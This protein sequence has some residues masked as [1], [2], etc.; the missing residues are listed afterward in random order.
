MMGSGEHYYYTKMCG[1]CDMQLKPRGMD[2]MVDCMSF[3]VSYMTSMMG[4]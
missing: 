2:W 3:M 1:T 4:M